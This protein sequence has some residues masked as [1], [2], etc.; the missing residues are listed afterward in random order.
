MK[1]NLGA[2]DDAV[3]E[4]FIG[5][6]IRPGVTDI[7]ADLSKPWPFEDESVEEIRGSHIFEHLPVP[8]FTMSEA[9]RVLRPGGKLDLDIPS[10]NGMGAFQDPTHV[11][12]WNVNS[13]IYYDRT[14][15]MG[16]MYG[17]NKWDVLVCQEYLLPE[18]VAFGPFI[19][20][21][22]RKPED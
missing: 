3:L 13:F 10:T 7:T 15:K 2:G 18:L 12:F 22:L 21:I 5:V 20:A 6:D 19:K 4:G 9:Y 17:C 14:N 8:L 11:S 1:L 16:G